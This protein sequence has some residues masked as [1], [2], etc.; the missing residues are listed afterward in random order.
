ML[1]VETHYPQLEK[2]VL[3]LVMASKKLKP[4]FQSHNIKII[5]IFALKFVLLRLKI[6]TRLATWA[7]E[8]GE[9]DM[10]YKPR[11]AIKSKVLVDFITCF[12]IN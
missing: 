10:S 6:S 7:I 12:L 4:Y 1:D 5:T 9:Y 2:L 11:M 3:A 8:L